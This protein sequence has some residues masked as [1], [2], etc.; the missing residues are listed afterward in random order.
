MFEEFHDDVNLNKI[1][2]IEIWIFKFYISKHRFYCMN[3][4]RFGRVEWSFNLD[5]EFTFAKQNI[6][7]YLYQKAN[8]RLIF[9]FTYFSTV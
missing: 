1:F 4:N 7:I 2:Y 3:V 5:F 6:V 8:T 9:T